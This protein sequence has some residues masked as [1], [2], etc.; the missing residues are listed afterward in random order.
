MA[1]TVRDVMTSECSCIGEG[2]TVLEAARQLAS[3]N[4]GSMPICGDDDKLKGMV[5]DRDIVV[6]VVAEGRDPAS[7]T[8]GDLAQGEIV[9]V[10]ADASI[11]DALQL[12]SERQIRRL[13]V[14]EDRRLAGVVAQADLARSLP[15][16]QVGELLGAISAGQ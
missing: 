16:A 9:T 5:T 6:K 12:M 14:L 11:E 8:A 2:D 1:S 7:V 13:P 3:R 10:D 4:I 15:D